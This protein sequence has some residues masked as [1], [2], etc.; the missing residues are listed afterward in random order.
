MLNASGGRRLSPVVAAGLGAFAGM[1]SCTLTMMR[2]SMWFAPLLGLVVAVVVFKLLSLSGPSVD[3]AA[4]PKRT[5]P[6][7]NGLVAWLVCI[8]V[9][10]GIAWNAVQLSPPGDSMH[11]DPIVAVGLWMGAIF[12]LPVA[13]LV[14]FMSRMQNRRAARPPAEQ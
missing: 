7:L 9:G 11:H 3:A 5:R 2:L 12:G 13:I 4:V 1:Y 14:G 6:W 8:G 10:G